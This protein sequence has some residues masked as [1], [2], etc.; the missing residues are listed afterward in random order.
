[1]PPSVRAMFWSR[2][3]GGAAMARYVGEMARARKG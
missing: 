3:S 2:R 1:L